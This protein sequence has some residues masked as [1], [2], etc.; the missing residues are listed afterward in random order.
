MQEIIGGNMNAAQIKR[1]VNR[2][3]TEFEFRKNA[4]RDQVGAAGQSMTNIGNTQGTRPVDVAPTPI[5]KG[6]T[7]VINGVT[8]INLTGQP[9]GWHVQ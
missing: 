4:I 6:Q 1:V 9:D 5:P 7:K 8:Y 3:N 2:L